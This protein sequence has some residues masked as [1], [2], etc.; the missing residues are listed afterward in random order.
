MELTDLLDSLHVPYHAGDRYTRPGWINLACVR[1]GKDP[2][3]GY[4]RAGR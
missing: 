1:C 3:L 4:N 2:Y